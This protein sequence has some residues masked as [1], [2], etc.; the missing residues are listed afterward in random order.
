M[1]VTPQDFL[2]H[3]RDLSPRIQSLQGRHFSDL[4]DD[5]GHQYI[6]LVM[7][8]GGTLGLALLGY[9]HVMESVG[10]RFIGIG[11]TSAGAISAIALAASAR[12]AEPRVARLLGELANMPMADFVDGRKDGDEDALDAL[13]TWLDKDSSTLNCVWKATRVLDNLRDL[14]ALNRGEV[15]HRWM[16]ELL[17][18]TNQQQPLSVA[19]LRERMND[20]PPLWV[21]DDADARD[22]AHLPDAPFWEDTAGRRRHLRKSKP[23]QLCVISADISTE[24][25]VHFP[26]MAELYWAH[27]D[28]VNVADF[29]RASMSIPAFF[30]TFQLPS[31]PPDQVR[32]RWRQ[33]TEWPERCYQGD[34]LPAVHHFVDGG[35][36]SNFPIDA[37]HNAHRVPLRPT[38]GIKLQWDEHKHEVKSVFQVIT[39]SFNT[40]RHALDSEFINH[41]PDFSRLVGY[42]DTQDVSW[43]DFAMSRETKLRLFRMGAESAI[44]FLGGFDWTDYK[45]V[46]RELIKVNAMRA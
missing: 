41:N 7:E 40:A 16:D 21:S 44:D 11:G 43:L 45:R 37:F 36:L 5:E 19:R 35:V 42:I 46:R 6:D 31:L 25:K 13:Q 2:V 3:I 12:P 30:Q 33:H 15:F 39:G 22:F 23:D 29:A 34:F 10:L 24:T 28:E 32:E 17:R 4:L 27:P 1:S 18:R 38:L 9:L 14:D 26:Q 8:G 20:L